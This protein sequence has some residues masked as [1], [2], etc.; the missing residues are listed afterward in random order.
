MGKASKMVELSLEDEDD[1]QSYNLRSSR[2]NAKSKSRSS[3]GSRT[4][5]RASKRARLSGARASED[6]SFVDKA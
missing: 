4:N 2:S 6:S 1:D 5:P 3:V